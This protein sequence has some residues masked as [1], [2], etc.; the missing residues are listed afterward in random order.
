[1]QSVWKRWYFKIIKYFCSTIPYKYDLDIEINSRNGT[2]AAAY[3][4]CDKLQSKFLPLAWTYIF[5]LKPVSIYYKCC[6]LTL[7]LRIMGLVLQ[8]YANINWFHLK[9]LWDKMKIRWSEFVGNI[10][11]C[12]F[13][14]KSFYGM[15]SISFIGQQRFEANF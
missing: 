2:A 14:G 9:C 10:Y 11:I 4:T 15:D 1:M 6:Q 8:K 13:W 3:G 7:Y 5:P 12:M